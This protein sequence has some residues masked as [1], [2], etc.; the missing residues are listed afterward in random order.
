MT[1][2]WEDTSFCK[3]CHVRIGWAVT[4]RGRKPYDLN[5][6]GSLSDVSHFLTCPVWREQC[7][8]RDERDRRQRKFEEERRQGRLF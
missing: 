8:Q 3:L 4:A 1:G 2:R 7:K 5:P 6:D